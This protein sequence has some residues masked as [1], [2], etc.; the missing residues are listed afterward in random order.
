MGVAVLRSGESVTFFTS[1]DDIRA[2]F[3]AINQ[4]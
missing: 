4:Q 1:I 2:G 3:Y